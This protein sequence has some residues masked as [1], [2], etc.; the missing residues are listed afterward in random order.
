MSHP[1]D[2]HDTEYEP[3]PREWVRQQ[4]ALYEAS[5]GLEG[6]Q[7]EGKPVVI[8]THRG[9]RSGKIRKTPLMRMTEGNTYVIVASDGG[10]T[11]HPAWYHNVKA[12]P[13]V[14][15]QDKAEVLD[16]V[17]REVHGAERAHWW[18]VA[19]AHWP[20]FPEY[21]AS[22]NREIPVVVLEPYTSAN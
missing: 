6:G 12:Q 4:V 14:R 13:R 10:S 15:L 8:L 1:V 21:R 17:A 11:A 22:A 19:E 20:H 7:L 5:N 2:G 18:E 9:A 16:L 3:N